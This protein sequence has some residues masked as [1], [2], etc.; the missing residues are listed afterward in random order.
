VADDVGQDRCW[1]LDDVRAEAECSLIDKDRADL[2]ESTNQHRPHEREVVLARFAIGVLDALDL[3][4]RRY[5]ATGITPA[6]LDELIARSMEKQ[7]G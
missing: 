7:R 2:I 1:C 3:V 4:R 5:A 6:C